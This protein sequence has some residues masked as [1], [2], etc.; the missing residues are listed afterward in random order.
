MKYLYALFAVAVL[1]V[2]LDA[3]WLKF[4]MGAIFKSELGE[5]ALEKPRMAAAAMFYLLYSVGLVVFVIAQSGTIPWPRTLLMGALFGL[6]AYGTYDL[7]NMATLRA[8]S[9]K[10][11]AIDVAWGSFVTMLSVAP[12]RAIFQLTE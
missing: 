1:L 9:W 5:M 7:T 11:V 12:A 4:V 6:V 3:L 10:L 2:A 8:W